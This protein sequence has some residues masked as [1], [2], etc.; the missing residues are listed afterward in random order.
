MH[1]LII[2]AALALPAGAPVRHP[3]PPSPAAHAIAGR[4]TD[5][6]GTPLSDVRVSA[7]EAHRTTLTDS[8]GRYRISELPAGTFT[9]SFAT[10]GRRPETRRV[11]LTTGDVSL[12]VVMQE[13]LVELEAVQVSATPTATDALASPQPVASRSG[14]ELAASQSPSLGETLQG[15][16]GVHSWSTGI[17]IG[18]PV[19]RGLTSN[20]VLV[21]DDGQRLETQQWGDEHSANVETADAERIEVIRG[22]ASVLYGSDALGGVV[23]IIRPDLPDAI[24][25]PGFVHGTIAGGYGSN[26]QQP[27][28]SLSFSGASGGF[29]FRAALSGRRSNDVKTPAYT[30]WNSGNQAAGGSGTLGYRGAWGSV[31]GTW[32]HRTEHIQMTDEDPAATPNQRIGT[33]V[34][35]IELALPVGLSR[36][37]V[38]GG[39]E[40]SRR[41]EFEEDTSTTVGLGLL[42]QTYTADVH[43]HHA[44][45]GRFNGILGFLGVHSSFAKFGAETLIPGS[46]ANNVGVYAFEQMQAGPW[47]VSAGLRYDYRKLDVDDDT[48][49]GVTAQQRTY[50]SVTGNL[51]LLY[52]VAE[53]VAIVLNLGRGFRAPSSFDLFSNGV[54]EGTTAFEHGN[55]ALKDETSLN[56]DL[57]L[58]IRTS[59]VAFEIGAFV[60]AIQNYIYSVPTGTTDTASGFEIFDVTQGNARLI[61]A[62]LGIQ[63]HPA[64][65]IHLSVTADYVHGQNPSSGNALPNMPPLRATWTIRYEPRGGMTLSNPYLQ[66]GGETNA[67][68]TRLDPAEAQFYAD[69]F[70]GAG[71]QSKS[72]SLFNAG[73]GFDVVVGRNLVHLS[74]T[75]RNLFDTA[76]A[77]F[78]SRIKTNALNPGMGRTLIG[79]VAVDF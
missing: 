43:F 32:S 15:M 6:S 49:I 69:A 34:G 51:G 9:L 53:P 4:V 76:Y 60:N 70:G 8:T 21:L 72:Y 31:S 20:R 27:D 35:R 48:V 58:R 74:V 62:E 29:G 57:A 23:N 78:L 65:A 28:A 67:R 19:I 68:Q 25:H 50:S 79:R 5:P 44:P 52:R 26:N 18:K 16:P 55:P 56:T 40:R 2:A 33:D 3:A 38:L 42:Q 46:R 54:H 77:D 17:G 66:F 45:V 14:E 59:S 37:E 73:G 30:L 1:P 11:S 39:Y 13:T 71:Y 22:P 10:I 63:Y 61:G 47:G 41:R 7:L 75:A 12:D 36:I 64:R 24:G